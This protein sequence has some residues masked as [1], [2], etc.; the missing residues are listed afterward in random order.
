[1]PW[2]GVLHE[3]LIVAQIIKKF[4]VLYGISKVIIMFL[5][6]SGPELDELALKP[7]TL[8]LKIYF[9]IISPSKP[10]YSNWSLP[11]T[12]SKPN[13]MRIYHLA[14]A[15]YMPMT[16][17]LLRTQNKPSRTINGNNFVQ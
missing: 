2:S 16:C 13:C 6:V 7:P 10:E 4:P 12:F 11:Y 9:N 17:G 14:H 5:V 3:K 8:F 15:R 1:M